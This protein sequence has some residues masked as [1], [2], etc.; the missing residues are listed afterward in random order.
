[1][2]NPFPR[3]GRFVLLWLFI[4]SLLVL[5]LAGSGS[6]GVTVDNSNTN[7]QASHNYF[8]TAGNNQAVTLIQAGF[9]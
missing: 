5:P 1:M 9:Q 4:V 2:T 7:L 3:S 6:S 8:A